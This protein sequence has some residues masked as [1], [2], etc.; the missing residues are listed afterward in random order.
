MPLQDW[1]LL[2]SPYEW[3]RTYEEEEKLAQVLAR[4]T[5]TGELAI[6]K[7]LRLDGSDE[8]AKELSDLGDA[9]RRLEHPHVA[10]TFDHWILDDTF[11]L[12]REYIEGSDLE[13]YSAELSRCGS[14][15]RLEKL[16]RAFEQA[17]WGLEALHQAGIFL[18]RLTPRHVIVEKSTRHA[19]LVHVCLT[20]DETSRGRLGRR[21]ALFETVAALSPEEL[22]GAFPDR[23]T[24][25]YALGAV[26]YKLLSGRSP[27]PVMSYRDVQ[28][29][30]D[31]MT[32]LPLAAENQAI[33]PELDRIVLKAISRDRSMRFESARELA[34]ALAAV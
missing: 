24:D 11:Y 14:D 34:L 32:P 21:V 27:L 31:G 6:V 2:R 26:M 23:M 29:A 16:T 1:K 22:R 28:K 8:R 18:G 3:I 12:A 20:Q 30:L 10:K 5:S 33:P 25:V 13:A 17:A 19:K 15:R 4:D 9:L 7:S